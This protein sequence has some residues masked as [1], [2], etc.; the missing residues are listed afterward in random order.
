MGEES[1]PIVATTWFDFAAEGLALGAT[2]LL[3][4]SESD[5]VPSVPP[6]NAIIEPVTI[7]T[8]ARTAAAMTQAGTR[9]FDGGCSIEGTGGCMGACVR[10]GSAPPAPLIS[11]AIT[12]RSRSAEAS[13]AGRAGP[14]GVVD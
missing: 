5:G 6:F 14:N 2:G 7:P 10:G 1:T 9:R 12:V 8:T 3:L 11:G 4:R 13:S